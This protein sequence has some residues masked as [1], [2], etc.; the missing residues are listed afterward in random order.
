M[1]TA[2]SPV[3]TTDRPG[4][5]DDG[6][7]RTGLRILVASLVVV[8]LVAGLWLW[9]GSGDT[10]VPE[11]AP[12]PVSA[13]TDVAYV[14]TPAGVT[15]TMD[16]YAP[17]RDGE[18]PVVVL[19]DNEAP[20]LAFTEDAEP[21][22]VD[23]REAAAALA[24]AV[25][26]RG[27]VVYAPNYIEG[28]RGETAL[29]DR[30]C[31]LGAAA[32][33]APEVGGVGDQLAVVGVDR[34]APF[35]AAI[36]LAG[37]TVADTGARCVVDSAGVQPSAF[38]GYGPWV[39]DPDVSRAA[40]SVDPFELVA[41]TAPADAAA[42]WFAH[43]IDDEGRFTEEGAFLDVRSGDWAFLADELTAAGYPVAAP[44]VNDG[45]ELVEAI[46]DAAYG[47]LD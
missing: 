26:E 32:A 41:E 35:G 22:E 12:Y 17:A 20:G 37:G 42:F 14:E 8:A 2:T 15:F 11:G 31:A 23:S 4:T 28:Y 18:W 39:Y 10:D 9:A 38:L 27:V 3:S 19:T 13:P 21:A 16:R 43:D 5:D 7:H 47:E 6:G 34:G 33:D 44:V 36:A 24:R 46:V 30:V 40:V 45:I 29:P 1:A 25:A